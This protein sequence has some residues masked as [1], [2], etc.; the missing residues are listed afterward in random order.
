MLCQ[1]LRVCHWCVISLIGANSE[2]GAHTALT[3][4]Q[5]HGSCTAV[6]QIPQISQP[7][8]LLYPDSTRAVVSILS[9]D[10]QTTAS[11]WWVRWRGASASSEV[12]LRR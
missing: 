3:R 6:R 8:L 5:A 9:L 7:A 1:D 2:K 11:P 12:P 10:Q 4:A